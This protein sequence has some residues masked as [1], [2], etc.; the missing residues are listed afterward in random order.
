M[1]V[2]IFTNFDEL[3]SL[4]PFYTYCCTKK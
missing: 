2:C 3:G 4:N 1:Y